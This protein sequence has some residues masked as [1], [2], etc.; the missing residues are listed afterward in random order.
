MGKIDIFKILLIT[1][2]LTLTALHG[3][4]IYNTVSESK[5]G[6]FQEMNTVTMR[7]SI[8]DTRTGDIYVSIPL[9]NGTEHLGIGRYNYFVINPTTRARK[10]PSARN[11]DLPGFKNRPAIDLSDLPKAPGGG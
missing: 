2:L 7:N 9:D 5:N 6:R 8:L 3:W 11:I 1:I 10:W 4:Y